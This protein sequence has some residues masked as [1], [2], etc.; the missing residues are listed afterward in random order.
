MPDTLD[1]KICFTLYTTS[2]AINRAY[3][4]MLDEM[5]ITYPQYLVL[6]A[7]SEADG[8]TVG[9]VAARLGLESSTVTPPLQRL[10]KAGLVARQRM[11]GDERQVEVRLTEQGRETLDTARCLGKALIENSDMT[12]AQIDELSEQIKVLRDA[13]RRHLGSVAT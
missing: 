5:G 1:N 4:P 9:A 2:I 12:S 8:M 13:L 10:E 6:N 11:K 3:K 7:L